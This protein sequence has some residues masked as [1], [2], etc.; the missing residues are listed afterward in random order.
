MKSFIINPHNLSNMFWA[1]YF[2]LL[3]SRRPK[4]VFQSKKISQEELFL[5]PSL[6]S[7]LL[8]SF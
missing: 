4:L 8:D 2:K 6:S 1:K 7:T 5:E 3:F